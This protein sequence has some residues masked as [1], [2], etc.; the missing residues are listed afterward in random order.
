MPIRQLSPGE[1]N[2]IAAGEVI[3]RPASA[4]KELVENAIDAGATSIEVV[5]RGGGLEFLRVTD[6]GCGMDA[7]DLALCVERHA[8]SKLAPGNLWDI[9][10]LGFRGEALPSLGAV[11]ILK[12]TTRTPAAPHGYQ[13]SVEH[14]KKSEIGPARARAGTCVELRDLFSTTPA[15]LK[16]MKSERA[17]NAAIAD[18]VK[19]LAL[20]CPHIGFSLTSGERACRLLRPPRAMRRRSGAGSAASWDRI[21]P[22]TPSRFRWSAARSRS[23]ALREGPRCTAQTPRCNIFL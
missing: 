2:R 14:G 15:R 23:P 3:E 10:T 1:I 13:I 12:I 11:G 17:E 4:V 21:S 5:A 6:N 19:R 18:V 22:R 16:F 9:K 20:A 7:A 8:T